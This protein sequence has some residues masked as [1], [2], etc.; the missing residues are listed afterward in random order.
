[1]PDLDREELSVFVDGEE[2]KVS[3]RV[4]VRSRC[5]VKAS[6]V[7]ERGWKIERAGQ[8]SGTPEAIS[9]SVSESLKQ[10]LGVD[11]EKHGIE[12][13][14]L[15]SDNHDQYTPGDDGD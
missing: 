15:L 8:L 1:M 2:V 4:T 10:E 7:D 11:V 12:V 3:N 6:G 9:K 14:D 5:T 13:V